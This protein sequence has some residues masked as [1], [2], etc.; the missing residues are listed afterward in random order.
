MTAIPA[1]V[2]VVE[3]I[4]KHGN[5]IEAH[6]TEEGANASRA[7][8]ARMG[9]IEDLLWQEENPGVDVDSLTDEE[10]VEAWFTAT[11][12]DECYVHDLEVHP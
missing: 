12:E 4:S 5:D 11:S 7:E 9:L 2:W 6:A 1:R 8:L 10:A 3:H